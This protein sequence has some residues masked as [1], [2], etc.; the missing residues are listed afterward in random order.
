[1]EASTCS[2]KFL[3]KRVIVDLDG[4][5]IVI[6]GKASWF[7]CL[8]CCSLNSSRTKPIGKVLVHLRATK[9]GHI[10]KVICGEKITIDQALIVQ[11]FGIS[12]EGTVDATNALFKEAQ[13]ALKN[14]VG[15]DYVYQQR[16]MECH[17][18]EGG[19]PC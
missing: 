16:I 12:V 5:Q 2:N 13:V 4:V 11:Q 15:L 1:L 3:K 7:G 8:V 10:K 17:L 19:V 18:D 14:I 6:M 9:D